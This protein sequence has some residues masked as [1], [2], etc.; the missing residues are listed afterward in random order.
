MCLIRVKRSIGEGELK[1][2]KSSFSRSCLTVLSL[3]NNR[4]GD[5]GF[6]YLMNVLNDELSLEELYL[7]NNGI[8]E[9]SIHA[10]SSF[11]RNYFNA[12]V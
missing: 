6:S 3:N 2:V 8:T 12:Y 4:L 7:E 5:D 11:I 10:L 9:L 1:E